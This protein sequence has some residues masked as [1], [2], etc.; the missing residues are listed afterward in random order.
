[1]IFA[2]PGIRGRGKSTDALAEFVDIYPTLCDL[3]GLPLP[4]HLQGTS[5]VPVLH[6][7][8]ASV[9][10][11]AFSQYPRSHAGRRLMGYSMRTDRWRYTEWIDRQS[12][13]VVA[14]E[15]YDQVNDP[16]ENVNTAESEENATAVKR[17]SEQLAKGEGWRSA[18]SSE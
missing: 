8:E 15:L 4:K 17:L 7:V 13:D 2:A 18:P 11:A 9:K 3:A 12:G 16:A 6:D 14:R 5:L 1:M 10:T